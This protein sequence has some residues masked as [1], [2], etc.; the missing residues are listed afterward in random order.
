MT[1]LN[2]R[3]HV[4]GCGVRQDALLQGKTT[5]ITMVAGLRNG[6]SWLRAFA[7][8]LFL[9]GV[10][11]PACPA[12]AQTPIPERAPDLVLSGTM[13][14]MDHQKYREVSFKVPKGTERLMVA[15]EYTGKAQ[16]TTL[17][18]GLRDPERFRGWSGGNKDRVVVEATNATPSYLS[19]PI[20]S[21]QWHL[22]IGV[23]NI[24][25]TSQATY[26]ARIWFD[27]SATPFPGFVAPAP[28]ADPRWFRGDLHAH[29][30]HSDGSCLSVQGR[31]VPCPVFKTLEAARGRHLDFISVTDHNTTS[32]NQA[33]AELAPYFDDLLVLPGRE[34]TTFQGHANVWGPTQALDFQLGTPRAKTFEA[35]ENQ[36]HAAQG[37]VSINHPMLPSG[38]A[39]MGCG[40][41]AKTDWSKVDAIEVVNGGSLATLG[42]EGP[43]SGIPF[44]EGLLDQGYRITAVG[45][46]DNHDPDLATEKPGTLGRPTTYVHA[47]ALSQPEILKSI[48]QGRVFIDVL[49]LPSPRLEVQARLGAQTVEMGG[50][51]I[52][53][54]GEKITVKTVAKGLPEGAVVSVRGSAAGDLG[55][56]NWPATAE[57][58][59]VT[60][61]IA[62]RPSWVRFDI[63]TAQ[64]SLI[65]LGNP[66]YL[67]SMP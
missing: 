20:L 25:K 60:L 43:M 3:S 1:L 46:S 67:R 32:Q 64:G 57:E 18:I 61:S 65:L 5:E 42:A 8:L 27:P 58:I 28:Q 16:R 19:G 50:T 6:M 10:I 29:T 54:P 56:K 34:I 48:R 17:D 47:T 49:G 44:W 59:E 52:G 31:R 36:V 12:Q 2:L 14:Q 15:F 38:E 45:G 23:P 51:L 22:I 37:L 9:L 11:A 13:S 26:T 66:I 63:R 41:T 53:H 7:S 21:G 35:I 39:C 40:W 33:L 62:E 30:A 4:R 24:R 55:Q